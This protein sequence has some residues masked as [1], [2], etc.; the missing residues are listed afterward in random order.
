MLL[1]G[2]APERYPTRP[3][4]RYAKKPAPIG[5]GR[6]VQTGSSRVYLFDVTLQTTPLR[7][8]VALHQPDLQNHRGQLAQELG[9]RGHRLRL[10]R[11]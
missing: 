8:L 2:F 5:N 7:E 4:L 6:T 9:V 3:P 10:G 11:S 1:L